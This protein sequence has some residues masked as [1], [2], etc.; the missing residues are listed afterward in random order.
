MP[1]ASASAVHATSLGEVLVDPK[2]PDQVSGNLHLA[3]NRSIAQG[4][5]VKDGEGV[6]RLCK[7]VLLDNG[8]NITL[9]KLSVAEALR[10][11]LEPVTGVQLSSCLGKGVIEWKVRGG[12]NLIFGNALEIQVRCLVVPE[13]EGD[14][15]LYNILLGN[16]VHG[17]INGYVQ[18]ATRSYCF[19]PSYFK[20]GTLQHQLQIPVTADPVAAD[21]PLT[22]SVSV[23]MSS[24][25]PSKAS[26][27]VADASPVAKLGA[28]MSAQP[29]VGRAGGSRTTVLLAAVALMVCLIMMIRAQQ[30]STSCM[31]AQHTSISGTLKILDGQVLVPPFN[32]QFTEPVKS[33]VRLKNV[34]VPHYHLCWTTIR[35]SNCATLACFCLSDDVGSGG[36][37]LHDG[38]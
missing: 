6:P 21:A 5:A 19:S 17:L 10:L 13:Q 30:P 24:V 14:S 15:I 31:T 23:F 18:P 38:I 8:S 25:S 4:V 20:V 28:H 37:A 1:V 27:V 9:I 26:Q 32:R 33:K 11:P 2:A 3:L 35:L 12:L 16:D 29:S 7:G 36:G 34:E 22:A